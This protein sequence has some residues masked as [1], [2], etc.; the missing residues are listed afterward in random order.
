GATLTADPRIRAVAF[1]GSRAAGLALMGVAARR[2]EPIPVFAEMSSVNPVILMPGVLGSSAERLAREFAASLTQSVG[3]MCTNPGIILALHSPG[4]QTFLDAARTALANITP[5]VM[6]TA[7]IHRNYTQGV[8]HMLA[9][10]AELI[11]RGEAGDA[12]NC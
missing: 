2:P 5:G 6:L 1:T 10:G 9:H 7:G 8:E 4:L 3:Q 12:E 11:A